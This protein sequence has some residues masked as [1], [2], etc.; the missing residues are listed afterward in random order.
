MEKMIL[1][2]EKYGL[3]YKNNKVISDFLEIIKDSTN[4]SARIVKY[5]LNEL[6]L[7]LYKIKE[8]DDKSFKRYI[9]ELNYSKGETRFWGHRFELFFHSKLIMNN[10]FFNSIKRGKDGKEPDFLLSI[11]NVEL[12]IELTTLQFKKTDGSLN[13]VITKIKDRI[14]EKDSKKYAN[15]KCILAINITNLSANGELNNYDL[16]REIKSEREKFEYLKDIDFNYGC[17]FFLKHFYGIG[18]DNDL[19]HFFAPVLCIFDDRQEMDKDLKVLVNILF[20]HKEIDLN[21]ITQEIYF[22]HI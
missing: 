1:L 5:A 15:N 17:I 20:P 13:G 19:Q 2:F 10:T 18:I 6:I 21:G 3:D 14:I 12:G 11:N 9:H 22:S 4:I 7:D 8:I 16:M